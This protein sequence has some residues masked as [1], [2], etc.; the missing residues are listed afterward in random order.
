MKDP[1]ELWWLTVMDRAGVTGEKEIPEFER[2]NVFCNSNKV[3]GFL[4]NI[5]LQ[6]C[7]DRKNQKK[8]SVEFQAYIDF[9]A[10]KIFS[11]FLRQRG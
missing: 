11:S 6:A 5:I 2:V 4:K 9:D 1:F 7:V 3:Y 10:M 8:S